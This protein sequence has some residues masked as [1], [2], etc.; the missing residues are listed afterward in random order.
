[1]KIPEICYTTFARINVKLLE[2]FKE[3]REL[4]DYPTT[5]KIL[6]NVM[7]TKTRTILPKDW[8]WK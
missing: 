6:S 5:T 2:A 4:Q 1:M 3:S 7:K 8:E